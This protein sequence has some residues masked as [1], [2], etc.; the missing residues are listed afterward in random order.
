MLN[1]PLLILKR[2]ERFGTLSHEQN[3]FKEVF[4]VWKDGSAKDACCQA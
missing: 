2:R 4:R 3:A 1:N